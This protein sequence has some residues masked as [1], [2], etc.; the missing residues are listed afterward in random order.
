MKIIITFL[1]LLAAIAICHAQDRP[2]TRAE[3]E[4]LVKNLKYQHGEIALRGGLAKLNVPAE[5]K[6]LN[7]EDT[8]TVL[9]KLWDNPPNQDMLGMLL[10]ADKTP[11]QQEC[12]AI[13]ISYSDDGYVKDDDAAK[14]N[15]D[16]L[17][18]KMK[19][20]VHDSNRERTKEGYPTIELVGWAEPPRYDSETHKMYWAKEIK[21]GGE[22]EN[23]LNYNIR[24]LGRRGVLILNVIGGMEQLNQ[25]KDHTPQILGMVNFNEGHRYADFDSKNDK[26]A[27]YGIAALVA[28]GVA[29]KMGFFKVIWVF[30]LAAKKF[31]IIT[32]VAVAAW[33]K[34]LFSRS[35]GT[36]PGV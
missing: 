11:L 21:F 27:A 18:K 19:K 7:S 2:K 4:Q 5:F 20:A 30:L 13:T 26:V 31:V 28:G 29:A 22:A 9:T 17:L 32:F 16:D 6:F 33:L 10:P 14:I 35:K 23:T 34:R 8:E 24:I 1:S 12:W 25:I 15:Y 36:T 3:I